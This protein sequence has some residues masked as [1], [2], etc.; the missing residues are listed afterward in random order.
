MFWSLLTQKLIFVTI[1][2]TW[3]KIIMIPSCCQWRFD[4]LALTLNTLRPRQYGRHFPDSIF[5]CIFVNENVLTWIQIPLKFVRKG[6]INNIPSLVQIM[7]WHRP[8][9]KP[10]SEPMMITLLT[11][12]CVTRPQWVKMQSLMNLD[13]TTCR[14]NTWQQ[15]QCWLQSKACYSFI[16]KFLSIPNILSMKWY[17]SKWLIRC[18]QTW[19]YF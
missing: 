4:S 12:I 18:C 8:G 5:K 6:P 16:F 1:V 7:A 15:A 14:Y 2:I 3:G 19:W 17:H 9:D 11:H 10:L 13:S